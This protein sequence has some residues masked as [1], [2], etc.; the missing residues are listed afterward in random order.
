MPQVQP[1]KTKK[2]KKQ[3]KILVADL[4]QKKEL[5]QER[6]AV[7]SS[8]WEKRKRPLR[9]EGREALPAR[10]GTEGLLSSVSRRK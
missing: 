2:K 9:I 1:Y 6:V 5:S 3:R 8:A 7:G 10:A 4:D